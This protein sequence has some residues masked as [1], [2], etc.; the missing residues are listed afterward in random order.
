[1]HPPPQCTQAFSFSDA[2]SSQPSQQGEIPLH[3]Q[4]HQR[5]LPK[6]IT[7]LNCL[8]KK[9]YLPRHKDP[10]AGLESPSGL[11]FLRFY[12]H[13]PRISHFD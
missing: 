9:C 13:P 3:S 10:L 4:D 8:C 12:L 6:D 1:M 11:P 5:G 7:I 2:C